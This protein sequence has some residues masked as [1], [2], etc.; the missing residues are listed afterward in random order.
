MP[1]QRAYVFT[2]FHEPENFADR[3]NAAPSDKVRYM[4]AQLEKCPDSGKLHVQGYV[5]LTESM[6]I[7]PVKEILGDN[8]AHLE[9]RGGKPEEV[10]RCYCQ[11]C[12]AAFLWANKNEPECWIKYYYLPTVGPGLLHEGRVQAHWG[13][14]VGPDGVGRLEARG[15]SGRTVSPA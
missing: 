3:Y 1:G 12:C 6:G 5:E 13:W 7:K 14:R 11:D 8:T 4:V 2:S 10:R 15:P 9:P